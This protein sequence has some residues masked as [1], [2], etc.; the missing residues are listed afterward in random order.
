MLFLVPNQ[1]CQSTEGKSVMGCWCDCL[2]IYLSIYLSGARCR[3]FA[4]GPADATACQNPIISCLF[5]IQTGFTFLVPVYP[6]CPEKRP[7]KCV[8]V[9][10]KIKNSFD[11]IKIL[12]LM[13][14]HKNATKTQML[15]FQPRH[16]DLNIAREGMLH[17]YNVVDCVRH[18]N[19]GIC[20]ETQRI[21]ILECSYCLDVALLVVHVVS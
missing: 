2:S 12:I 10:F 9:Y 11:L 6:G 15:T 18:W 16:H 20:E 17:L 19:C 5:Y 14:G 21:R 1:Q 4:Y 8:C 7:F 13:V 3:L